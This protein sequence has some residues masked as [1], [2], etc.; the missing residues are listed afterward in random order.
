[1]SNCFYWIYDAIESEYHYLWSIDHLEEQRRFMYLDKD[2]YD[3]R[4][5]FFNKNIFVRTKS[6]TQKNERSYEI[7]YNVFTNCSMSKYV[8]LLL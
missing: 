5:I 7:L 1:M 8:I 6:F 4:N 2:Y 3:I